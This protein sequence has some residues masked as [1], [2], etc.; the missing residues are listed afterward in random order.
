V[1][2]LFILIGIVQHICQVLFQ[3]SNIFGVEHHGVLSRQ[4]NERNYGW[5]HEEES[6]IYACFSKIADGEADEHAKTD[7]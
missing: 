6:R 3:Q 4:S 5:K 7:V 1:I 2:P